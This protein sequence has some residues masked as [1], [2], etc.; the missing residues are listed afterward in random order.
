MSITAIRGIVGLD[1]WSVRVNR[2]LQ[3]LW[4]L[5]ESVLKLCH[6]KASFSFYSFYRILAGK[7]IHIVSLFCL[8]S[9]CTSAQLL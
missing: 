6:C 4:L 8:T 5:Q 9:S 7:H 2:P 1:H 3:Q